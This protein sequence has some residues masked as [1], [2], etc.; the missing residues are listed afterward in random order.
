MIYIIEMEHTTAV[1]TQKVFEAH[2]RYCKEHGLNWTINRYGN[3][4]VELVIL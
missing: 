3:V 4:S 1:V 2:A